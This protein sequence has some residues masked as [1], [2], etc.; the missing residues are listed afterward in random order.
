MTTVYCYDL[1]TSNIAS[2]T[3]VIK[4]K[5]NNNKKNNNNN[6]NN[7]NNK[8]D[9]ETSS[10]EMILDH[11]NEKKRKRKKKEN[12]LESNSKKK[13]KETE[14]L[15]EKK[16]KKEKKDLILKKKKSNESADNQ[17]YSITKIGNDYFLEG[18][19]IR[20]GSKIDALFDDKWYCGCVEGFTK[21]GRA[22]LYFNIDNSRNS[23]STK[24]RNCRCDSN[25][26]L[27]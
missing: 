9:N 24:L 17:S 1:S 20:I 22:K 2:K 23:F 15:G 27:K 19:Q 14:I 21:S 12:T 3:D 10:E 25:C 18:N 16:E 7:N 13:V 5:I 11:E 4:L 6:N 8:I 26:I